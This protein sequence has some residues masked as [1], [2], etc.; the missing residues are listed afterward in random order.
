VSPYTGIESLQTVQ[1]VEATLDALREAGG[2]TVILPNPLDPSI[3]PVLERHGFEL[4][5][6]HGL[7]PYVAG[8]TRP[9]ERFWPGGGA[10]IKWVDTRH[11]HPAALAG[12]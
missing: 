3:F 7:R 8:K 11:L 4:L 9:A 2:N 6:P 1:R 10:V 12:S 5:T